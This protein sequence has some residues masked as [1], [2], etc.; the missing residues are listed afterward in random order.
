MGLWYNLLSVEMPVRRHPE[1]EL[2]RRFCRK[3]LSPLQKGAKIGNRKK[4][5]N[6]VKGEERSSVFVSTRSTR[7]SSLNSTYLSQLKL[8]IDLFGGK[9][10]CS[11]YFIKKVTPSVTHCLNCLIVRLLS[12]VTV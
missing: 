12:L 8:E 10:N 6:G 3:T 5:G 9:S 1:D 2:L 7:S 4:N 11:F